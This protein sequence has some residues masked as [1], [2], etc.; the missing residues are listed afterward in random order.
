MAKRLGN[1]I[2]LQD[3]LKKG[4][5]PKA[6]RYLLFSAHYKSSLNFTEESLKDAE[7]TVA[8]LNDFV[9]RIN[10]IKVSGKYNK[11]L[12]KKVVE[13]KNKFELY[14]DDDFNIPQALS[15]IFELIHQTNKAIDQ[16]DLSDVNLKE[17][18]NQ[19]MEFDKILGIIEIKK[20]KL[21]KEIMDLIIK[22]EGYRKRGD[23]EAA[24]K[25]RLEL[26]E[27]GFIVEDTPQGTR[28]R[29]I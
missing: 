1:F 19:M 20:E 3:L 26:R 13:S 4:Y 9:D 6:I 18:Y 27:K 14:M 25:I 7:R 2:T 10:K 22:R 28:W 24:D 16:N 8:N 29:K 15:S 12:S 21:P 17:V 23:F 11:E 5:N